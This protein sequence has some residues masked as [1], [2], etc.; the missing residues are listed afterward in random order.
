LSCPERCVGPSSFATDITAKPGHFFGYFLWGPTKKVSRLPAGTGELYFKV[1]RNQTN[2]KTAGSRPSPCPPAAGALRCATVGRA[3]K[4]RCA[5]SSAC[6]ARRLL[7]SG[8]VKGEFKDKINAKEF[9][10]SSIADSGNNSLLNPDQNI[11]QRK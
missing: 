11:H 4:I 6:L 2:F 9:I 10:K 7:H 5:Q 8:V 3:E 1:S